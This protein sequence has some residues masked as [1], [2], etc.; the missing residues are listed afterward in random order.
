MT[1]G[2]L[3]PSL[4]ASAAGGGRARATRGASRSSDPKSIHRSSLIDLYQSLS[5]ELTALKLR[6]AHLHDDRSSDE[7]DLAQSGT[8][9]PLLLQLEEKLRGKLKEVLAAIERFEEGT[10]GRCN[11]C[12]DGIGEARLEALP[13]A[14]YCL[15]CQELLEDGLLEDHEDSRKEL[16]A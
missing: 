1:A 15:R 10:Y 7:I 2:R 4:P 11:H 9:E 13:M 8:S 14:R 12:D 5:S 16:C 6:V 3:T